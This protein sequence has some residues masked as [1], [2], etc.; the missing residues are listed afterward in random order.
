[1]AY[2]WGGSKAPNYLT[3]MYKQ[4]YIDQVIADDIQNGKIV[5]I[6]NITFVIETGK[7]FD[8]NKLYEWDV[9]NNTLGA[10]LVNQKVLDILEQECK[11]K[12]QA[13]PTIIK[14]PNGKEIKIY[15]TI[16]ITHRVSVASLE[17]CI[18]KKEYQDDP[19]TRGF[20][21]LCKA[22]D[23]A[24]IESEDLCKDN[25]IEPASLIFISERLR[26]ILRKEK[27]KGLVLYKNLRD[28]VVFV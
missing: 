15:F 6:K 1:M 11:G 14:L 23:S 3:G 19:N 24:I 28:S 12:F 13:I 4:Q 16:N 27:V 10:P 18:K 17:N 5:G 8:T 7:L 26:N 2:I 21:F 25:V 20:I 9:L 22:F